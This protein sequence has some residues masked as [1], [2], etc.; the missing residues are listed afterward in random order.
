[1]KV[2]FLT[3]FAVV[4]AA[5]AQ[6]EVKRPGTFVPELCSVSGLGFEARPGVI[7]VKEACVGKIA[8]FDK[9]ALEVTLIDNSKRVYEIT[10]RRA[11][12][13]PRMGQNKSPF[14]GSMFHQRVRDDVKGELVFTSG[15]TTSWNL[16]FKTTSNLKFSGS[17]Q[18]VFV[19]Q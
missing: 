8:G 11:P 15:I 13:R 5:S 12:G 18:Q 17:L 4:A 19:T 3:V 9:E 6:A 2:F 1:M 14:E 10:V 7:A 16:S